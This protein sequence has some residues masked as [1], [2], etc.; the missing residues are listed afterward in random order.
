L[1]RP[2]LDAATVPHGPEN[3]F[4]TVL[5]LAARRKAL[6]QELVRPSLAAEFFRE[7]PMPWLLDAEPV[8]APPQRA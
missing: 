2:K 1:K 5:R 4:V 8:E 3:R 6:A 7:N